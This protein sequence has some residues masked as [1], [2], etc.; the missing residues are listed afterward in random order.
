MNA[1]FEPEDRERYAG[2]GVEVALG[3]DD[4]VLDRQH[5]SDHLLRRG[6]AVR[7]GHGHHERGGLPEAF[8]GEVVERVPGVWHGDDLGLARLDGPLH[9]HPRRATADRVLNKA[10]AVHGGA[11]QRKEEAARLHLSGIGVHRREVPLATRHLDGHFLINWSRP[12]GLPAARC[13][14]RAYQEG[15]LRLQTGSLAQGL[16]NGPLHLE[17]IAPAQ[18]AVYPAIRRVQSRASERCASSARSPARSASRAAPRRCIRHSGSRSR[19]A[20]CGRSRAS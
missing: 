17:E 10:M 7:S 18:P 8:G 3:L 19:Y 1:W 15:P 6:L 5:R 20:A 16:C 12:L 4:L 14:A 9:H 2:F 11:P 13:G